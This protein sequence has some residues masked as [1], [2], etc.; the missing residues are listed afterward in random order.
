MTKMLSISAFLVLSLGGA[1]HAGGQT[2]SLGIGIESQIPGLEA[3]N[4]GVTPVTATTA[5]S[6]N[7]DLGKFHVGGFLGFEDPQGANNTF[8]TFGGRFYY[9]LHST[10]MSDF[11]IGGSLG[12][13]TIPVNSADP[14]RNYDTD[15]YLEPSFQI[16]T[17]IASNVALSFTGGLVI[18]V[19]D[20]SGVQFGGQVQ[21]LAGVHYYFF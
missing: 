6:L 15:V 7:Y 4:I 9:H 11:G 21:G 8:L 3:L 10:A 18:G 14:N 17:F 16:R 13:A 5:L 2:G 12:V 20:A 19:A 1:A